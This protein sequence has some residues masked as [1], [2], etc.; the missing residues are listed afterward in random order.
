MVLHGAA[1]LL[2]VQ[3]VLGFFFYDCD[4]C[5]VIASVPKA[6]KM[7][8]EAAESVCPS[9]TFYLTA[10]KNKYRQQ[11]PCSSQRKTTNCLIIH[12]TSYLFF[13]FF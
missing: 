12:I 2:A 10:S 5:R 1:R 6:I 7:C 3:N 9:L 4:T 11:K 8:H 13:S